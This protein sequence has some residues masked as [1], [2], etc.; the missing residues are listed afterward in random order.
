MLGLNGVLDGTQAVPMHMTL[1]LVLQRHEGL[2]HHVGIAMHSLLVHFA[3]LSR[4]SG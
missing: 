4:C 2:N 1:L 3:V